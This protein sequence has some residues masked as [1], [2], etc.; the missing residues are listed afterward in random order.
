MLVKIEKDTDSPSVAA[1]FIIMLSADRPQRVQQR[2]SAH[3]APNLLSCLH[4]LFAPA[5]DSALVFHF[6]PRLHNLSY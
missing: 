5:L 6:L 1:L 4:L 2:V 3:H